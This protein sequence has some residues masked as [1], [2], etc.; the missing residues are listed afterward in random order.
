[1]SNAKRVHNQLTKKQVRARRKETEISERQTRTPKPFSTRNY[2][3]IPSLSDP[4]TNEEAIRNYG[5]TQS[6][7]HLTYMGIQFA[8][9]TYHPNGFEPRELIQIAPQIRRDYTHA[10]TQTPVQKTVYT[11]NGQEEIQIIPKGLVTRLNN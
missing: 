7:D 9:R 2:S 10:Q 5:I 3:K 4:L 1:M 6:G 8:N 11:R